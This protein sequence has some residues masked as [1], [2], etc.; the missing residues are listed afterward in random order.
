MDSEVLDIVNF[1]SD[2]KRGDALDKINDILFGKASQA[3]DDYKKVVANTFFDE[4]T[5]TQEEE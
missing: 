2:K 4:P 1:I 5:E 3:I